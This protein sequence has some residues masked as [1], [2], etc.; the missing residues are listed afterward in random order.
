MRRRVIL[1]LLAAVLAVA[2]FGLADAYLKQEAASALAGERPV[3]VLVAARA[4]P[5]GTRASA[6]VRAGLLEAERFPAASVPAGAVTAVTPALS[7]L[8]T[9]AVL[10]PGE[11]L[12]RAALGNRARDTSGLAV[13]PGMVVVTVQFC[14]A[15]AVAG[16]VKAGS[17]VAVYG[18]PGGSGCGTSRAAG[19]L[20]ARLILPRVLV[21]ATGP[22]PAVAPPAST[23]I[24]SSQQVQATLLL[25]VAI[26]QADA[27]PLI[28]LA[29]SGAP[30][31][32]L[33]APSGSVLPASA[34]R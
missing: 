10:Q 5:A 30:Y 31:L 22:A 34:G 16:Y 26:P 15:Q 2:G 8:V 20:K 33:L 25:T 6:A 14:L 24:G 7:R 21:L 3:S 12:T 9:D 18:T 23:G 29:A 28:T 19:T 32:A 4:I 13:P 27:A 11:I 17:Q 1:G